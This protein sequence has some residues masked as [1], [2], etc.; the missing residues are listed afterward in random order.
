MGLFSVLTNVVLLPV[1]VAVDI[2]EL[3][4]HLVEGE[5]LAPNTT[6]GLKKIEDS[7]DD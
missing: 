7:L 1:R 6:K 4:G 2:V 5:D 3:P